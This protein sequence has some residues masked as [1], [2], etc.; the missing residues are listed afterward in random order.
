MILPDAQHA[1]GPD[2]RFQ[3]RS[4]FVAGIAADL[5]R[6]QV[7]FP[8]S[9]NTT[10]RLRELLKSDRTGINDLVRVI[11]ADPLLSS[12]VVQASNSVAYARLG[13]RVSDIRSAVVRIGT[14]QVRT[15]ATAVAMAQLLTY[16]TMAPFKTLCQ[17]IIEHSRQVAA[18][19]FVLCRA[20]GRLD[21]DKA[22]FAGLIHDIGTLYLLFRL[23]E[24]PELFGDARGLRNLLIQW[25]NEIGYSV[26][27]ALAV[28]SE[29]QEAMYAF[30]AM[31][32]CEGLDSLADA[33]FI[34]DTLTELNGPHTE[35]LRS[36]DVNAR[37]DAIHNLNT[38]AATIAAATREIHELIRD[39]G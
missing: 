23:S 22:L 6:G 18:Y 9:F 14:N 26:M 4:D 29:I 30:D 27:A 21:G 38:Y 13:K 17:R 15:L 10:V 34:A 19:A 33:L 12:R 37:A 39:V 35:P 31:T 2:S 24:H 25:R 32:G 7:V 1:A 8:T 5:S 11:S 36:Y 16:R 3:D 28:T 20:Q